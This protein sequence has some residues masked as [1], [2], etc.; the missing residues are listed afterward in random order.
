MARKPFIP[1][2]PRPQGWAAPLPRSKVEAVA[3]DRNG[4]V[5]EVGKRHGVSRATVSRIR[6]EG[7]W[8]FHGPNTELRKNGVG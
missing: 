3:A 1:Y 7:H 2:A 6:N 5:R 8:L 4:S